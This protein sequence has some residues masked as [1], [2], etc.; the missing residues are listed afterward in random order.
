MHFT[1][2]RRQDF[3]ED[4][5]ARNI[6]PTLLL[7]L[8]L[9]RLSYFECVMLASSSDEI[10]EYDGVVPEYRIR[11]FLAQEKG[12]P[13]GTKVV[14]DQRTFVRAVVYNRQSFIADAADASSKISSMQRELKAPMNN[15]LMLRTLSGNM[16]RTEIKATINGK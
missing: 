8:E 7:H 13:V 3:L 14:K 16:Q 9:E 6:E 10:V 15:S 4:K 12:E 5:K 2:C 11:T 1:F